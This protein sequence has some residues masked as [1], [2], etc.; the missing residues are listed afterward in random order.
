MILPTR[1]ATNSVIPGRR[2][3]PSPESMTTNAEVLP[4]LLRRLT[5]PIAQSASAKSN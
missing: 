4:A 1:F 5:D 3:A 2:N